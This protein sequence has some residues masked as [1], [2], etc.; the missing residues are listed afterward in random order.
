MEQVR[1]MKALADPTRLKILKLIMDTELC[2]CDLQALLQISQPAVSQHMAKLKAVGLVTER[3]VGMWTHYKGDMARVTS[4]LHDMIQFLSPESAP[5]D[6][7][8]NLLEQRDS[9]ERSS[10]CQ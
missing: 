1:L 3:K 8:R 5:S 2:V 7:I 6:Q 4:G 10:T 9:L